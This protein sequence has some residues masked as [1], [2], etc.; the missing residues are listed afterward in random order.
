MPCL[1]LPHCT[2][3][4]PRPCQPDAN[5]I[6]QPP[7]ELPEGEYDNP[8]GTGS[9]GGVL[10]GTT[11]GVMEAALRTVYELVSGQ[12]MGRIMFEVRGRGRWAASLLPACRPACWGS[13]RTTR[14]HMP[15]RPL[16]S[17]HP[18]IRAYPLTPPPCRRCAAWTASKRRR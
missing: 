17:L 1:P 16:P 12:P 13:P 5:P 7:Q 6:P 18:Q 3:A 15:P 10:F 2:L 11:G 14:P 4:H 9:G 8:L